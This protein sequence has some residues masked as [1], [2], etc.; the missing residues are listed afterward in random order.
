M[1]KLI[2]NIFEKLGFDIVRIDNVYGR[3]PYADMV[4]II[5]D[6]QP[7][8]FDVGANV[9]QTIML[10]R[11]YFPKSVI[12]SFEPNLST[13]EILKQNV[14]KMHEVRIWN[15]GLGSVHGQTTFFENSH[16]DMSSFLKLDKM[17]WGDEKKSIAEITTIDQFCAEQ[18]IN[19]IDLLKIDTQGFELEILKGAETIILN[20]RVGLIYLEVIFSKMYKNLPSLGDLYN[21]LTKRG[22]KLVSIYKIHYQDNLASWSDL[23]FVH[24]SY[25]K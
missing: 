22:Y 15:Y 7:M 17:G 16:S 25:I 18:K 9:G 21:F 12:N 6:D 4:R 1:K 11:Q 5:K 24:E 23:L 8:I 20:N 10:L 2:K 14:A 19:T 13:F 3:N